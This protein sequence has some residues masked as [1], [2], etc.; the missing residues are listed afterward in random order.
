MPADPSPPPL[1]NI[2]L[3]EIGPLA[4]RES[5]QRFDVDFS[6]GSNTV[7]YTTHKTYT[8]DPSQTAPGL[9]PKDTVTNMDMAAVKLRS[10]FKAEAALLKV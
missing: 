9:S 10:L 5:W 2:V 4:Y 8:F 6:H 3:V 7:A 1:A